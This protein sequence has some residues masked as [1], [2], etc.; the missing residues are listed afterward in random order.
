MGGAFPLRFTGGFSGKCPLGE[1]DSPPD[2]CSL[3][4]YSLW[5]GVTGPGGVVT[6]VFS[7]AFK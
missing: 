5:E 3:G 4:A 6:C 7:R 2:G 1:G